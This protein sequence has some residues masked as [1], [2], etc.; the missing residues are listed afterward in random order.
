MTE[1]PIYFFVDVCPRHVVE[2]GVVVW[3]FLG[4][5]AQ[6]SRLSADGR[7]ACSA[8]QLALIGLGPLQL[9]GGFVCL[10]C[11]VMSG[12]ESPMPSP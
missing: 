1:S 7:R 6:G 2:L 5:G 8:G 3:W 12:Y 11:L 4:R 9:P 10:L